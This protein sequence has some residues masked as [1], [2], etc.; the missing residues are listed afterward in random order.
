MRSSELLAAFA[1]VARERVV[2]PGPWRTKS[3]WNLADY[4]TTPDADVRSVYH[5]VLIALDEELGLNNGMPSLYAFL[6]DRIPIVKGETVVHLGCGT[7]YYSAILAEVVGTTGS[8]LAIDIHARNVEHA[9]KAL[10]P[11]NQVR[12]KHADGANE[13][14]PA[15]DLIV[16]SAG[17]THPLPNW[18]ASLKPLGR[19][20]F[21]LTATNG[22]GAMMLVSRVSRTVFSARSLCSVAFY[23]FSGARDGGVDERLRRAF[24]ASSLDHV[25]SVRVDEHV[26][27]DTCWLHGEGWCLSRLEP[28]L[29]LKLSH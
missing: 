24:K 20:L 10:A 21:P 18:L 7:G 17:A 15:A 2:G 26:E 12:V 16:V 29:L 11:W 8:V 19:L 27:D 25:R 6:L 3:Q 1:N 22:P 28:V 4:W 5:D 9:K 23:E 14:L 13:T